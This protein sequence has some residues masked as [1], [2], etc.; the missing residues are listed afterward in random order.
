MKVR[1]IEYICSGVVLTLN[2]YMS[3]TYNGGSL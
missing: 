3:D 1:D 2:E